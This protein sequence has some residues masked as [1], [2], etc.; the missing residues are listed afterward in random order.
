MATILTKGQDD[1]FFTISLKECFND[2]AY[3]VIDIDTVSI[4]FFNPDG[5]IIKKTAELVQDEI[6]PEN[7]LIRLINRTVDGSFL[8][9]IG[10]WQ[11]QGYATLKT[12]GTLRTSNRH[13]FWV[14]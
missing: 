2:E 7:S 3:D 11:M 1:V 12:T 5:L 8:T 13:I 6:N 14:E 10:K 9:V 4:Q